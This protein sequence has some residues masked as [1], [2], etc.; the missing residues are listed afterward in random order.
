M[1]KLGSRKAHAKVISK[2]QFDFQ[3][4][5]NPIKLSREFSFLQNLIEPYKIR[6]M[7]TSHNQK[8]NL[9]HSL[10][11][12]YASRKILETYL[13][14]PSTTSSSWLVSIPSKHIRLGSTFIFT[15]S[16]SSITCAWPE[17]LNSVGKL[18]EHTVWSMVLCSW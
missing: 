12:S 9:A 8:L 16:S 3:F 10:T 13:N 6:E 5:F 7:K 17:A 14:H 11:F 2:A 18:N 4:V 15:L 1:E